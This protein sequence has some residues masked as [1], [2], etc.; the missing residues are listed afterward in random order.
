MASRL[1]NVR[2]SPEDERLAKALRERGVSLSEIVR[3][4]LRAA[5]E[6]LQGAPVNPAEFEAEMLRLYP[7]PKDAV[8]DRPDTL[9]RRAVREHVRAKLRR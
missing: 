3:R 9:D 5:A 1:L 7:T 4:A 2:L 8:R 6:S